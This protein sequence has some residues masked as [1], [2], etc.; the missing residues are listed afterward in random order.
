MGVVD[1]DTMTHHVFLIK[2]T[3]KKGEYVCAGGGGQDAREGWGRHTHVHTER[4]SRT[5]EGLK[6]TL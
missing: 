3:T 4:A 2:T 1:G 5:E 6:L